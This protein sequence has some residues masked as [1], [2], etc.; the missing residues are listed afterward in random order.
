MADQ[1]YM[2]QAVSECSIVVVQLAQVLVL[3]ALAG[4]MFGIPAPLAVTALQVRQ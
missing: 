1:Q 2:D 3:V 4:L